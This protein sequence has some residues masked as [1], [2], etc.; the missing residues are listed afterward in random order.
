MKAPTHARLIIGVTGASG[1]LYARALLRA[2]ATSVPG[3]SSLIVSPA[4]LRVY[5]QELN[6]EVDSAGALVADALRQVAPN[7]LAHNFH[8]EEHAD[9]GARPASGS[10]AFDG[11]VVVPC[12]MKTLAGIANGYTSSLVERAADVCLKERRR[13]IL[14]P[15]ETP[16]HLIHLRNM[17]AVT[18]AGAVILP[19]APAFYQKPKTFEDLAD[20][21]AGR[22]LALFG[23]RHELFPAWRG[24][25]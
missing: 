20:F 19:A 6:A 23:I 13:L 12:S 4:A 15:R 22:I 8:I 11:M 14:V 16:L 3:E 9:I 18:E 2:L 17:T 21:I 5:R 7:D 24:E 10:A 25:G 1:S